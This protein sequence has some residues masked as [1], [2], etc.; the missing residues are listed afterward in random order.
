MRDA[1]ELTRGLVTRMIAARGPRYR[2]PAI[3][4]WNEMV[5]YYAGVELDELIRAAGEA[6]TPQTRAQRYT[7]FK[8]VRQALLQLVDTGTLSAEDRE[9]MRHFVASALTQRNQL[10]GLRALRISLVEVN[11]S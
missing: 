2:P 6:P 10:S 5:E 3:E 4:T 7:N 1:L 9:L 11:E 8:R